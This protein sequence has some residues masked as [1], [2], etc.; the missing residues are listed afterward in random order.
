MEGAS[1][2]DAAASAASA[3]AADTATSGAADGAETLVANVTGSTEAASVGAAESGLVTVVWTTTFPAVSTVATTSTF[4]VLMLMPASCG[5]LRWNLL[6]E[7]VMMV[8]LLCSLCNNGASAGS[9]SFSRGCALVRGS[10]AVSVYGARRGLRGLGLGLRGA[11]MRSINGCCEGGSDGRLA[12]VAEH[13][14]GMS[15]CSRKRCWGGNEGTYGRWPMQ[16]S[17]QWRR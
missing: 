4:T 16:E 10:D 7:L 11:M 1:G 15:G 6:C 8:R 5:A 9:S 14:P 13:G 2:V 12:V 17:S 3:A